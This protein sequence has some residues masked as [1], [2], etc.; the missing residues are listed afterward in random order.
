MNRKP[1]C[2][3]VPATSVGRT[4]AL[5]NTIDC[6]KFMPFGSFNGP[7]TTYSSSNCAMYVSMSETRI[8]LA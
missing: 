2:R 4:N 5:S 8:S 7:L 3:R 6:G 1:T